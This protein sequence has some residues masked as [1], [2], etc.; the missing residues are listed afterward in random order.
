MRFPTKLM[1]TSML[2]LFIAAPV[3]AQSPNYRARQGDYYANSPWV[4][5][6]ASPAQRQRIRQ[7]DYYTSHLYNQQHLT[8]AQRRRIMQGDYYR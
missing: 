2:T 8:P 7:G 1:M 5:Q 6:T 4:P 3:H